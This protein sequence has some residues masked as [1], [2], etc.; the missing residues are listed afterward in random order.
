MDGRN[1]CPKTMNR[2]FMN[3]KD[4]FRLIK[5]ILNRHRATI[6]PLIAQIFEQNF[7]RKNPL[8]MPLPLQPFN[9]TLGQ[10]LWGPE[11]LNPLW[12]PLERKNPVLY[13]RLAIKISRMVGRAGLE[14]AVSA[15]LHVWGLFV[16]AALGF[17]DVLTTL[18]YRPITKLLFICVNFSFVMSTMV[19]WILT[20]LLFL[21]VDMPL[22]GFH[23]S[24]GSYNRTSNQF[25]LKQS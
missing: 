19:F 23:T 8:L 1:I 10:H 25:S 18:D 22:T 20:F 11:T 13:Q 6:P 7:L 14:P 24:R 4:P 16:R 17:K 2:M 5:P 3:I 9:W 12:S 21:I 15:F